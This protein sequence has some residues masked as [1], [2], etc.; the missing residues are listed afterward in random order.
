MELEN[1][2]SI[3]ENEHEVLDRGG[4]REG[5][6]EGKKERKKGKER[7]VRDKDMGKR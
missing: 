2:C 1:H 5:K 6:E 4:G 3:N 7:K